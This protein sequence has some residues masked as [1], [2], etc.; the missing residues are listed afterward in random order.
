M[1]VFEQLQKKQNQ[2]TGGLFQQ[3]VK[4]P[5]PVQ[6]STGG[7]LGDV[8]NLFKNPIDQTFR[9]V[10][11][12][13]N[14]ASFGALEKLSKTPIGNVNLNLPFGIRGNLKDAFSETDNNAR[15][16]LDITGQ[17]SGYAA[18]GSVA[19]KTFGKGG[20]LLFNTATKGKNL[21]K[22]G[23][24]A[25]DAVTGTSA[26]FGFG[27]THQ[28]VD[29]LLNPE[30]ATFKE[31]A[32]T[33]GLETALGGLGDPL[34][35]LAGTG[36]RSLLSKFF[37]KDKVKQSDLAKALEDPTVP[38]EVKDEILLLPEG[39][40]LLSES[41]TVSRPKYDSPINKTSD[42]ILALP[43]AK[44]Q[45]KV[46]AKKGISPAQRLQQLFNQAKQMDLPPGREREVLEDL[47]SRTSTY[48]ESLSLDKLIDL[49]SKTQNI[50]PTMTQLAKQNQN[51]AVYGVDNLINRLKTNKEII[52][53]KTEGTPLSF[54]RE[55]YNPI[56]QQQ[57]QPFTVKMDPMNKTLAQS[58]PT[59]TDD[60]LLNS[61]KFGDKIKVRQDRGE[62]ELEFVKR[63][64]NTVVVRKRNGKETTVPAQMVV[65][66]TKGLGNNPFAEPKVQRNNLSPKLA[67]QEVAAAMEAPQ[68]NAIDDTVQGNTL[69]NNSEN[70]KNKATPLL[71]RETMDRNFDDIMGKDAPAMKEQYLEPIRVSETERTNFLNNNRDEVKNLGIKYKSNEDKLV[72]M[73]GEQKISLEDLKKQ[74]NNWKQVVKATEMMREKYDTLLDTLNKEL[75]ENGYDPIPKRENYFP[76][77]EEVDNMFTKLGFD[78]RNFE[79][80]TEII[81]RT[82]NFKP[83]K[84]FFA[85][86]LRRKGDETTYGFIEGFDKYIEGASRVIHHTKNIKR[87]RQLENEIRAKHGE[88]EHL[89]SF[90]TDLQDYTNNLAGKQSALDRG[91]ESALG[92]K[93]YSGLDMIR[94]RVSLN[95]IGGNLASAMTNF[96]PVTQALATTSKPAFAKGM[97]NAV[98]NVF[99]NDGFIKESKFLTRRYGSD[100]LSR[101][102]L[103][104]V[105]DASMVFMR[106]FDRFASNIIVRSKYQEG[107]EKGLSHDKAMKIADDW[108]AKIMA[109]RSLGQMPT[110]FN[111]KAAGPILQFQLEVNNQLSFLLKDVPRNM[112]T[113]QTIAALSQVALYGYLFNNLYESAVGRRPAL[114]PIGI[115][116]KAYEDFNNPN[117]DNPKAAKNTT[118]AIL[119]QLPFTSI[120]EGG[121]IPLSAAIPSTET[122][123]NSEYNTSTVGKEAL[124]PLTYLLSPTSG[125][126]IKKTYEGITAMG[127]NPFSS[128]E[129][130]GIYQK[131]P[132]GEKYLKYPVEDNLVNNLKAPIFGKNSF[133][134]TNQYYGNNRR[135]L[136]PNQT[137]KLERASSNGKDVNKLYDNLQF[138]RRL[139]TLNA[140]KKEMIKD[141]N[142][143]KKEKEREVEKINKLIE[144][145]KSLR[146][147]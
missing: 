101:G 125:G 5:E 18:P 97:Y 110:Y 22:V 124:K 4:P 46:N 19:Y 95:M 104:K 83:G 123:I 69:L 103:D 17:L 115:A 24:Y 35:R 42:D 43:E 137:E 90:V 133:S 78:V 107:I 59:K 10:T 109:D 58:I 12:A 94:R 62:V 113:P 96:I 88:S 51:N 39:Q 112:K 81:G 132:K 102:K 41:K 53:T 45:T 57:A 118:K 38:K 65:G 145:L 77:Y 31:R 85:N 127:G 91:F 49:A 114:D 92:R 2:G 120:V 98:V 60:Q 56:E 47:W 93:I 131:N 7:L 135:P 134:E 54:K 55:R 20:Q 89:G 14:A 36:L 141:K 84:N 11:Q 143:T 63:E 40:K 6:P 142:L 73:Y 130:P 87:L 100:T 75:V 68:L 71:K 139:D 29:E 33:V 70:W 21:G 126:Q 79:L 147:R 27:V 1:G 82:Q 9:T 76:H 138:N 16:A 25:K 129:L 30:N 37:G 116:A 119:G 80:P 44:T 8:K 105:I 146:V 128:Q 67:Q 86:A 64:G 50:N 28:G 111:S 34:I 99:K 136:S 144:E 121:R 140:K 26:G 66:K 122:I 72:Q 74:T 52:P 108:A 15:K 61:L 3:L 106:G 117:I 48:N 32:K 23:K 13:G